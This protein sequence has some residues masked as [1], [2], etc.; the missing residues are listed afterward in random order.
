MGGGGKIGPDL[1]RIIDR[2]FTPASLAATMWNH[3]PAMWHAMAEKKFRQVVSLP[4]TPG[5][6]LPI[7]I[8][9][10]FLRNR[11]MRLAANRHSLPNT[12]QNATD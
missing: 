4:M 5:T 3:A 7:F 2:G 12:A 9:G 1:G 10:A 11:G 8:R 6:C